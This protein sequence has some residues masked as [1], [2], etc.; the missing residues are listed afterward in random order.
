MAPSFPNTQSYLCCVHI[1]PGMR[2][3]IPLVSRWGETEVLQS[4][5]LVNCPMS[6]WP[7]VEEI[8]TNTFDF[9]SCVL[10]KITR[11]RRKL[12]FVMLSKLERSSFRKLTLGP[13]TK[14]YQSST[15]NFWQLGA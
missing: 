7:L 3:I 14:T 5:W 13:S 10:S 11:T 2:I 12:S 9:K 4:Y 1:I 8:R 15:P 6:Q